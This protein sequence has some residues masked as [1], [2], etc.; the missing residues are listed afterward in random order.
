MHI[1]TSQPG[2]N[3]THHHSQFSRS[4][5]IQYIHP[6]APVTIP[7]SAYPHSINSV[8]TP[9]YHIPAHHAVIPTL[10]IHSTNQATGSAIAHQSLPYVFIQPQH[11]THPSISYTIPAHYSQQ[12]PTHSASMKNNQANSMNN[13]SS[14]SN[15][16]S[17]T[18]QHQQVTNGSMNSVS[19]STSTTSA[20]PN[21][22]QYANNNNNS[23]NLNQKF[24][25]M[26]IVGQ[27]GQQ[28]P[29]IQHHTHQ[30]QVHDYSKSIKKKKIS[31]ENNF[32]P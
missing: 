30:T 3:Q 21:S 11:G 5:N 25:N 32:K 22:L 9:Y 27:S 2:T 13:S 15:E 26:S 8:Q 24:A 4:H 16:Q 6:S 31:T 10:P 17:S 14:N 19:P 23:S 12:Y 1:I 18:S 7:A 29:V 20:T 28:I